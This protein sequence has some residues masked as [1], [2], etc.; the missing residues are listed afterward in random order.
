MRY[1]N[2]SSP[3]APKRVSMGIVPT[4][5]SSPALDTTVNITYHGGPILSNVKVYAICWGS[6]WNNISTPNVG[7][8]LIFDFFSFLFGVDNTI[9]QLYEYNVDGFEIGKGSW[10][11]TKI[12]NDDLSGTSKIE[13]SDIVSM[14]K[15]QLDDPH[16][17]ITRPGDVQ[18]NLIYF[19]YLQPGVTVEAAPYTSCT[20]GDKGMCGYHSFFEYTPF[21]IPYAVIPFLDCP[22]C[23]GWGPE[24]RD[25][26]TTT[27]YHELCETITNPYPGDIMTAKP[28]WFDDSTGKEIGDVCNTTKKIESS[29]IGPYQVQK[30]WSR[31]NKSCI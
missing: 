19:I 21:L 15:K 22:A 9:S 12:V 3:A 28:G 4:P 17:G 1:E 16:S 31:K 30:I 11:S 20:S 26:M 13:D 18:G 23:Q 6:A 25:A 29:G 10:V 2:N 5:N 7:P 24:I 27:T 14:L 8:G